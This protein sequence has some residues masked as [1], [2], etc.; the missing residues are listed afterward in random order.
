MLVRVVLQPPSAQECRLWVSLG[1]G[2]KGQVEGPRPDPVVCP[3]PVLL[4]PFPSHW[5]SVEGRH[6]LGPWRGGLR[7]PQASPQGNKG[8]G[9]SS[10]APRERPGTQH[11]SSGE[12]AHAHGYRRGAESRMDR[13]SS[14]PFKS[15]H[16]S[17]WPHWSGLGSAGS[18]WARQRRDP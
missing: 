6:V 13:G 15:W 3:P 10:P 1:S 16:G 9:G 4:L 17:P 14:R 18:S 5:I 12:P 8:P 2:P 11:S 7:S